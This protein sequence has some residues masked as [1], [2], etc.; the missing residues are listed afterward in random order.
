MSKPLGNVKVEVLV[1]GSEFL[2]L[3]DR[4]D[5]Y[6]ATELAFDSFDGFGCCVHGGRC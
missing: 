6:S 2:G 3:V 1:E 4:Y 5:C